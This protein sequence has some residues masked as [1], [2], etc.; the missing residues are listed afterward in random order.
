LDVN[1]TMLEVIALTRSEL[2]QRDLV[3][4]RREAGRMQNL[5][6]AKFPLLFELSGRLQFVDPAK[7]SVAPRRNEICDLAVYCLSAVER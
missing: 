2:Q 1:E 5:P 7:N 6:G 3:A 4:D